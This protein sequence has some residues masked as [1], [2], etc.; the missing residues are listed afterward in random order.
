MLKNIALSISLFAT[1][2]SFAFFGDSFPKFGICAP[3]EAEKVV[4][5]GYKVRGSRGGV[6]QE[7]R[8]EMTIA[9]EEQGSSDWNTYLIP[10]IGSGRESGFI[11][12]RISF[13][14]DINFIAVCAYD[15]SDNLVTVGEIT[16]FDGCYH[17]YGKSAENAY[18]KAGYSI[19]HTGG[20]TT[21]QNLKGYSNPSICIR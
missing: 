5:K 8:G 19:P 21:V 3:E 7:E 1:L 11:S 2:P 4:I 18:R 10:V 12:P 17:V 20:T 16:N 14:E 9:K 15:S 13:R 6:T